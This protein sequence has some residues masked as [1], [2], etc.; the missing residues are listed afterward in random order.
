MLSKLILF[1]QVLNLSVYYAKQSETKLALVIL[2]SRF[3][4]TKW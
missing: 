2:K 1:L 4:K 3:R